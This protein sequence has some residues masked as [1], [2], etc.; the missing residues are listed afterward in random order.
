MDK[1]PEI[2]IGSYT[3]KDGEG[4]SYFSFDPDSGRSYRVR[5]AAGYREPSFLCF[6]DDGSTLYTFDHPENEGDAAFLVRV[7]CLP[8]DQCPQE[9]QRIRTPVDSLCH[10]AVVKSGG[11]AFLALSSY[12]HGAVIFYPLD[13]EGCIEDRPQLF[14]HHGSGPDPERQT[15]SHVH[16]ASQDPG[17]GYVYVQDLGMDQMVVYEITGEKIRRIDAVVT[18]PGGGPRHVAF[19]PGGDYMALVHEMG[20]AVTVYH[21]DVNGIFR[22][23]T[24][25]EPTIPEDFPG[26]NKAAHVA[27]SPDGGMLYASNRGDDS[28]VVFDFD[29]QAGRLERRGWIREGVRWPR[30]FLLTPDNRFLFCANMTAGEITVYRVTDDNVLPVKL[31]YSVRAGE[32]VCVVLRE[33]R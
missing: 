5:N 15:E 28:I 6:S 31:P 20:N 17:T 22:I 32:P 12:S 19:H 18:R 30:H 33:K 7:A 11:R 29:P 2:F 4:I 25:E 16:S 9:E 3:D 26:L 21:R 10:I 23:E 8:G 13:E 24:D 1:L 27:F 14:R